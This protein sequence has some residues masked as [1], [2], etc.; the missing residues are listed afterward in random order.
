MPVKKLFS[1][2]SVLILTGLLAGCG[3][4]DSVPTEHV[5]GEKITL[6]PLVYNVIESSWSSQLGD[7]FKIRAAQQRFM[8]INLSVTNGGA[9]DVAVPLF[10]LQNSEGQHFKESEN[11][12]GLENW[13]GLLR[14]IGSAQTLEGRILFDV[15]LTSYKLRLTDGGGPGAEQYGLVQIP[16]HMDVDTGVQTPAPNSNVNGK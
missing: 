5:M 1:A 2:P 6:G 12:E 7:G 10:E 11:G 3:H 16:L 9:G 15:P 14:T 8:T 4:G 13:L